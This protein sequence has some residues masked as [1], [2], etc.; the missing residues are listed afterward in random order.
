M[1]V[2]NDSVPAGF[3]Q[4]RPNV[5]R[6]VVPVAECERV[7]ELDLIADWQGELVRVIRSDGQQARVS[8][9]APNADAL[10]RPGVHEVEPGVLEAVVAVAELA[11]S[12]SRTR[13]FATNGVDA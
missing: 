9:L 4:A 13:E 12:E 11:T 2:G 7:F 6:L 1:H 8:L 5:H 10:G 3:E